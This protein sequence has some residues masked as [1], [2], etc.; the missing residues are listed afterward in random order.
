MRQLLKRLVPFGRTPHRTS[1]ENRSAYSAAR[2]EADRLI[3]A[4]NRSE[5]AGDP[6]AGC[7][8]YRKAVE[9]APDYAK[10][11]LNLGIGL[12]AAGDVD[13]AIESYRTA[14]AIDPGYAPANYNLATQLY[15]RGE[16]QGAASLLHLALESRPEFPEAHVA[17]SNVYDAQGELAAAAASLEAA[18][19]QRPNYAGALYNYGLVLKKMGRMMEAE[20]ALRRAIGV[21]PD[22]ADAYYELA[23]LLHTRGEFGE[24]EKLFCSTLERKPDHTQAFAALFDLYES[25]GNYAAAANAVEEVLRQRPDWAGALMNYGHVL[26]K[27]RR[28]TDSEAAYR[29]AI[30]LDP[31]FVPAYRGLGGVLLAQSRIADALEVFRSGRS[32]D[33]EGFDLETAE[34]FA[35]NYID[36]LSREE[37][38]ARHRA[39]GERLERKY[40]RRTEPFRNERNPERRLRVGYVSAD[41]YE[42][43]VALFAI[44]LFERHD[45]SACEIYCYS[46]GT[47]QDRVTRQLQSRANVWRDAG[48]MS[49][50]ELF[51]AITRDEIDI[52]VDLTG[53]AGDFRIGVFA[54]QA[55]PVQ[56]TWLGYP[57]TTGTTRVQYRIADN[58]T[59]PAGHS[60]RFHTETLVRLPHS[61]WCY[62]PFVSIECDVVPPMTRNGFVTFGSFNE[63]TKLSPSILRL[64]ITV[65]TRLPDARLVIAR[66]SDG[67]GKDSLIRD[68]KGAGITLER[69]T[70]APVVAL[71]EY[72]RRFGTVDIAFDSA[73]YSGTTTTCDTLWM[74]V[75]VLTLPGIT[76][77]SRPSASILTTLGLT[78]WIAATSEDYVRIAV[79]SASNKANIVR[80]R[81]SMRTRMRTSPLMDE[82]RFARDVE[83]AYRTMWRAWCDRPSP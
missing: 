27:L 15:A 35:L 5:D 81:E 58:I 8:H 46:T 67:P 11:H 65:L 26:K 2:D 57:N 14:L 54:R 56:A 25:Q 30:A 64:W 61:Q 37:I 33:P 48:S 80:L 9:V 6:R 78:G 20:A 73:P 13:G 38:F 21:D 71:D 4:G 59:E 52:L 68:L 49:D 22:N 50:P 76:S 51:E 74:G 55:A 23:A 28:L 34:L 66:V 18:L 62:R 45:Q 82:V 16:L 24:A 69:I 10:A 1:A 47:S 31:A 17:L 70:F 3:A 72:Y 36:D 40:P 79:D 44:P 29:R 12:A 43:P 83:N 41:F 39:F 77:A 53:H 42:H 19:H 63:F 32:F 7:E 75:P 60:E